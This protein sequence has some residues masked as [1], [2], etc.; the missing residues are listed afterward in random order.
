MLITVF[1]FTIVL[2]GS[3]ARGKEFGGVQKD[4]RGFDECGKTQSRGWEIPTVSRHPESG[5]AED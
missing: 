4:N 5:K 1:F 3:R 2:K